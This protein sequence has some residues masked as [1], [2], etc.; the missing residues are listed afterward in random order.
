MK[1]V[2]S[3]DEIREAIENRQGGG[4]WILEINGKVAGKGGLMFHYNR[5]Y[6]DIYMDVEEPFRRQGIGS[7]LVQELKEICYARGGIPGARFSPSNEASR[8]TLCRAGF[9]PF[10]N[11]LIGRLQ[12]P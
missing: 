6:G 7:F 5:P 10:A 4:E 11:I 3:D 1:C 2:T 8:R 12:V 9:A